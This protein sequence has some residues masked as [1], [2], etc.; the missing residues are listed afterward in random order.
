MEFARDYCKHCGKETKFVG[1]KHYTLVDFVLTF[2]FFPIE[3]LYWIY[4]APDW[5]C[6]ECGE[7]FKKSKF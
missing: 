5:Y 4:K 2:V 7:E 6:D 1:I 3:I